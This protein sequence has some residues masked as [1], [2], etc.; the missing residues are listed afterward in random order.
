MPR[1]ESV[2]EDW[3]VNRWA[4]PRGIVVAKLKEL[5]GIPDRIF[6]VPGGVAIIGEFKRKGVKGKGLQEKT[7]PWYL[8]RLK[9]LGYRAY[10]W[11]TK[12]EFLKTMKE[13]GLT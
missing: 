13:A 11:D 3:A 8:N 1:R 12:E 10:C 2:L 5:D 4:R 6:F 9:E 7:Q